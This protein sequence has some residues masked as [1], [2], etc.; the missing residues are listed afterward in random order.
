M[1][2]CI[3]SLAVLAFLA[4]AKAQDNTVSENSSEEPSVSQRPFGLPLQFPNW[5]PIFPFFNDIYRRQVLFDL[6]QN[7]HFGSDPFNSFTTT[8]SP[9]NSD[10]FCC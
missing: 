7:N 3:V 9:L 8:S 10:E 5:R 6:I 2:F 1:K 4:F